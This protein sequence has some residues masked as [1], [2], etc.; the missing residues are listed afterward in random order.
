MFFFPRNIGVDGVDDG[1]HVVMVV[2]GPG[3]SP[4]FVDGYTPVS[5]NGGFT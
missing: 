3:P 2:M 1:I 5:F 4:A